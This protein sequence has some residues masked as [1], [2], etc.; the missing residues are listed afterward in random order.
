M[1][2]SHGSRSEGARVR[3]QQ[4]PPLTLCPPPPTC[5]LPRRA[6]APSA[7]SAGQP[8]FGAAFPSPMTVHEGDA[9][10]SSLRAPTGGAPRSC[11]L[12][13]SG[14]GGSSSADCVHLGRAT[15]PV[16]TRDRAGCPGPGDLCRC[17]SRC[18]GV[19]DGGWRLTERVSE[20]AS[21]QTGSSFTADVL[22]DRPGA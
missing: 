2:P 18:S 7:H 6:R 11:V 14:P 8:A 20:R 12:P 9:P 19:Q 1:E 22:M 5:V 4:V 17:S 10:S 13:S 21:E 3:P 15:R 16:R